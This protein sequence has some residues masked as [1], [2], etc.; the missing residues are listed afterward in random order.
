MKGV[1]SEDVCVREGR[2]SGGTIT[3]RQAEEG[4]EGGG[5]FGKG[6]L[7]WG[8]TG[9]PKEGGRAMVGGK[10]RQRVECWQGFEESLHWWRGG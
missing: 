7:S 1:G 4:L 2:D 3:C 6:G 9:S 5:E 10:T 8:S